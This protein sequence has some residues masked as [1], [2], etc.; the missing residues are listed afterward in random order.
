[1]HPS[2]ANLAPRRL[3]LNH[4][5]RAVAC[6][7]SLPTGTGLRYRS[8]MKLIGETLSVKADNP[9]ALMLGSR[10]RAAVVIYFSLH[11]DKPIH[12]GA[13]QRATR[14]SSRSL[15]HEMA[16]LQALGIVQRER[17]RR[18]VHYRLANANPRWAALR[19]LVREFTAPADLLRPVLAQVPQV[20]A[21]FIFGSCARGEMDARSDID[22]FILADLSAFDMPLDCMGAMMEAAMLLNREVNPVYYTRSRLEARRE[23]G[24]LRSV[25]AGPKIWLVGDESLLAVSEAT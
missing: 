5:V 20:E 21:A 1:M 7:V 2:G 16:R 17:D 11:P 8:C 13:L 25:L 9:L 6:R 18:M 23:G 10:A 3:D 24:F 14:V 4:A 15:Q 19:W 12:F 22:I